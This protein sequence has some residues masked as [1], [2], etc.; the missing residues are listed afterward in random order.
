MRCR[1]E[2]AAV[3]LPG[4]VDRGGHEGNQLMMSSLN[5]IQV[6]GH[7]LLCSGWGEGRVGASTTATAERLFSRVEENASSW[8][9]LCVEVKR[10]SGVKNTN[11]TA[12]S[13]NCRR[14][15]SGVCWRAP[16]RRARPDFSRFAWRCRR[17]D[18]Q[19]S[20]GSARHHTGGPRGGVGSWMGEFLLLLVF[21]FVLF[22]TGRAVVRI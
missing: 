7:W 12:V 19:P 9:S 22:R 1:R 6:F 21:C 8:R 10:L 15:R 2:A 20:G 3:A 14:R 4:E 11:E 5:K 13:S 17:R 16:W 18:C